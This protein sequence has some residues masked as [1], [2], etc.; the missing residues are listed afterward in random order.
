[1]W[2]GVFFFR[3]WRR[4]HR[5]FLELNSKFKNVK[6]FFYNLESVNSIFKKLKYENNYKN[7]FIV[8]KIEEVLN[9]KFD[10]VNFGSSIEYFDNY[11]IFLEKITN[12]GKVIFFSAT[13]LFETENDK[14]KKNMVVKQVNTLPKIN[15]LYFFNKKSFY[16]IFFKKNF[17]LLFEKKNFT[18]KIDYK[19]F[20]QFFDKIDYL[21]FLF[22]TE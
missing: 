16:E 18:D 19:N 5:F 2:E 11:N 6:Y 4:Q 13:T 15:Y 21:D 10:F 7:L 20:K 8:E 9:N 1:M 14:Y 22:I 12:I 3:Y 17:K